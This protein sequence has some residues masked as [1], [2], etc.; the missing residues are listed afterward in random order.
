M[1]VQISHPPLP[2]TYQSQIGDLQ[3]LAESKNNSRSFLLAQKIT[4]QQN[5]GNL[6]ELYKPILNNRRSGWKF[7]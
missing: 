1:S 3:M 2:N 7:N 5:L 6:E 4:K